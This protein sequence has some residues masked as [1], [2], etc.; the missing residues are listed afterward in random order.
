MAGIDEERPIS[1]LSD[2]NQNG[3]AR[4]DGGLDGKFEDLQ[5]AANPETRGVYATTRG[6]RSIPYLVLAGKTN[7]T[8]HAVAMAISTLL[9]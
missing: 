9:W 2:L 3:T 5:I 1:Y 8:L 6:L 4:D 7:V